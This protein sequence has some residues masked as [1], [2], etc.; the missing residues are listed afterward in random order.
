[1]A[2]KT[3]EAEE[4]KKRIEDLQGKIA[5]LKTENAADRALLEQK[6]REAAEKRAADD[7]QR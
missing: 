4:I 5:R 7:V 6:E 2:D 1:M 3:D